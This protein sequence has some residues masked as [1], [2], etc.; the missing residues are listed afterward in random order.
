MQKAAIVGAGMTA[1]GVRPESPKKLFAEATAVA[2]ASVEKGM[3]AKDAQEAWIGSTAFGGW[4]LGNTAAYLAEQAGLPGIPARRVENACASSGFALRDAVLAVRSGAVDVALVGGFEKMNDVGGIHKRYWLGVSG[5]TPW[6][7]M[8]GATFPGVYAMMAA[9]HMHEFGTTREDL[10]SVAVKNHA[11]GAKNSK[12]QFQK[13]IT[14]EKALA[15]A[16]VASPLT[17]FDC[18]STTDGAAV[19]LLASERVARR[20]TDTPVWIEGSGAATDFLAVHDRPSMTTLEATRKA[21]G[22]A[23]R[24]AQVA[25]KDLDF[26]EV[27]DCFTIAEILATEDLGLVKKGEGGRFA[28][29]Q[30]GALGNDI[31][32]NPSGGLK[33]KGHPLG[34]TGAGQAVEAFE[35]LQGHAGARQAQGA[36]VG[37][38]H[39]VG[40]SGATCAV[41]VYRRG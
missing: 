4:Q 31:V 15:S 35:Q 12:A 33:A 26:A 13:A 38:T 21:A 17:M 9:R 23:Y 24:E 34:A 14:L 16:M 2:F 20:Y 18:C 11:H 39:N 27:H 7:R 30:R 36:E 1:F 40:G 37:L 3:D 25:P 19:V 10:A 28:R 32:I 29:E 5:D 6:E 22:Q 41:H 8:A